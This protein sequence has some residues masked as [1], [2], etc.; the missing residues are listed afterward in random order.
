MK[1]EKI[2]LLIVAGATATISANCAG[3]MAGT[4]IEVVDRLD[5]STSVYPLAPECLQGAK[6][7]SGRPNNVK[8]VT[9]NKGGLMCKNVCVGISRF[10]GFIHPEDKTKCCCPTAIPI[11]DD[12]P[13]AGSSGAKAAGTPQYFDFMGVG[14]GR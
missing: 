13:D 3:E 7:K 6:L 12:A 11:D 10:D 8:Y 5:G 2:L 1:L 14:N 9:K 4:L